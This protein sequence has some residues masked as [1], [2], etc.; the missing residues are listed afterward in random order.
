MTTPQLKIA[1]PKGSLQ[2]STY[3]LF[4]RAG[5]KISTSSRS[6]FPRMDDPELEAILIRAQEI[7]KRG[8]AIGAWES[9]EVAAKNFPGDNK[10]NQARANLTTKASDFVH[11]YK[12][13][14]DQ[15]RNN[16]SG[17]AL[18]WYLTAL[19]QYPTSDLAKN[20]VQRLS[21]QFLPDAQ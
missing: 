10:L 1:L 5:W 21:M 20:G 8:D 2:E 17:S 13:G 4:E 15:E 3:R 14:E 12:Q 7:E 9:V 6:Y 18:A 11:T 19:K 16:Q